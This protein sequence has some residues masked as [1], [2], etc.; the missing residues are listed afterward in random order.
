MLGLYR[1]CYILIGMLLSFSYI[2][3]AQ[4]LPAD[5]SSIKL[6]HPVELS[7]DDLAFV[8][9]L[10]ILHVSAYRHLPPMSFY[11]QCSGQPK[12]DTLFLQFSYSTGLISPLAV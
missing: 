10:P 5:N 2:T 9:S 7:A 11:N 1:T 3:F 4:V 12:V 8:R 6:R